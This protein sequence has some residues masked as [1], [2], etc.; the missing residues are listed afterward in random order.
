M[1]RRLLPLT[2]VA[3]AAFAL[4]AW[5]L[6]ARD[7][8]S[9]IRID[10]YATDFAAD[11]AVFGLNE[12]VNAPEEAWDDS[13]WGSNEDLNQ[14]Y[15]TWDSRYLYF[16]ATGVIWNNNMVVLFD[17][18]PGRGLESM[19]ALNSWR[20]NF[21]FDTTGVG[22][23]TGFAPDFFGATW[24]GNTSPKLVV[25]LDGNRV[26]DE[27][28]GPNFSASASFSQGNLGRA[29]E[30]AI[31]WRS[32]FLGQAG[33][34]TRDTLMTVGSITDTLH[35]FPPGTKIKLCGVVTAGGDGTSGPDTA[36]DNLGGTT[37]NSGALVYI[38]NWAIIDL[39]QIDD[40]GLGNGG[41]DG[42]AD[43]GVSPR[44]RI[45][46]RV[47]PPF[48]SKQFS[49]S[50]IQLDRPAF[51]PDAGEVVHYSFK[52]DQPVNPNDEADRRRTFGVTAKIFDFHGRAVRTFSSPTRSALTPS[53]PALDKWDGRDD[54]GRIVD[55]GIYVLRLT[56]TGSTKRATRS[57]VVVR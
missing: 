6:T 11:E 8:S 41:P 21:Q 37:D 52:L 15:I 14:I 33:L 2:L 25:Q 56:V 13:K 43:W 5:A 3:L 20:R 40:T 12:L 36:P 38:D 51:R 7:L 17:T 28:V 27:A 9:A 46:Y 47:R 44:T 4:P 30:F 26:D 35:R 50:E 54:A 23:G 48:L 57:M 42:I 1:I 45:T 10:G 16:A 22:P 31:P 39:D 49:A 34:G 55:P 18:V 19:T 29:M 24:D 53:D 32:V